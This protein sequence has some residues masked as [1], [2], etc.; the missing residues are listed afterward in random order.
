[1]SADELLLPGMGKPDRINIFTTTVASTRS[2]LPN[3]AGHWHHVRPAITR[4]YGLAREVRSLYAPPVLHIKNLVG[5]NGIHIHGDGTAAQARHA[6]QLG[7]AHLHVH[8]H[9]VTVYVALPVFVFEFDELSLRPRVAKYPMPA[10][11]TT[12][13]TPNTTPLFFTP[14][15][16]PLSQRTLPAACYFILVILIVISINMFIFVGAPGFC[17]LG[18]MDILI[19][20]DTLPL[21]FS[22]LP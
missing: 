19:L 10:R 1:M 9:P 16:P 15:L 5:Y 6:G 17:G 12:A 14:V 3:A 20:A 7:R 2:S 21:V 22:S 4:R 13:T 8:R 18:G 11:T